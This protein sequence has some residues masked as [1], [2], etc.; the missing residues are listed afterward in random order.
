MKGDP[1]SLLVSALPWFIL[2]LSII[3]LVA[4]LLLGTATDNP[5]GT[6]AEDIALSAAFMAFSIIGAL[7]AS[8]HP[9]NAI[10]WLFLSTG[11]PSHTRH[12]VC[13]LRAGTAF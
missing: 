9:T 10:G 8:R 4:A 11:R 7:I 2:I 12:V 3:L 13:A 1:P 5:Y 6:L